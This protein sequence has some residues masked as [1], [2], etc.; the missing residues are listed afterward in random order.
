MFDKIKDL[1]VQAQDA[2][3]KT[4]VIDGELN[5]DGT[6]HEED[7]RV[8]AKWVK[9]KATAMGVEVGKLGKEAMHSDLTKDAATGAGIGAAV[10]IP[11]PIIGPIAGAAIGAGLGVYRNFTKPNQANS[12]RTD[13]VTP[14]RDI[15][16]ELIKMDELRQKKI[17]SES[18]FE[19]QKKRILDSNT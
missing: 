5:G 6:F 13:H 3:A 1:T 9:D 2:I 12:S 18:E 14:P 15:Y 8:A 4:M 7:V 17:I 19:V 11:V 16:A 10:A